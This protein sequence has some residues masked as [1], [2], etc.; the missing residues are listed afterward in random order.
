MRS[1]VI[2]CITRLRFDLA[3]SAEFLIDKHATDDLHLPQN[4]NA[5]QPWSSGERVAVATS[6]R[7]FY[8]YVITPTPRESR[9]R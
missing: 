8:Y 4:V 2:N 3:V 5:L 1:K 6:L 7:E 9:K